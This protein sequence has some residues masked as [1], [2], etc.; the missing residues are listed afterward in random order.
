MKE[1]RDSRWQSTNHFE[2]DMLL[3]SPSLTL[4]SLYFPFAFPFLSPLLPSVFN[5]VFPSLHFISVLASFLPIILPLFVLFLPLCW[6]TFR[7]LSV[8][9]QKT[10]CRYKENMSKWHATLHLT[11]QVGVLVNNR[12]RP[13]AI[14][15]LIF[16]SSFIFRNLLLFP[17]HK[18]YHLY[19]ICTHG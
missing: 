7:C 6:Y 19:F 18:F 13:F 17:F 10:W 14:I 8:R 16:I 4:T 9:A 3:I 11:G 1:R 2:P 15:L 5:S 12:A